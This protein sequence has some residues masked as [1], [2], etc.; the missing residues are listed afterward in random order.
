MSSIRND[1]HHQLDVLIHCT[2][3]PLSEYNKYPHL[4]TQDHPFTNFEGY[5]KD[6]GILTI[7]DSA[8]AMPVIISIENRFPFDINNITFEYVVQLYHGNKQDRI[9]VDFIKPDLI[10]SDQEWHDYL[11]DMSG[12]SRTLVD[13][14]NVSYNKKDSDIPLNQFTTNMP[15][16]IDS[17]EIQNAYNGFK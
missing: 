9:K 14:E 3:T 4:M 11:F 10:K 12:F 16:L 6:H 5:K 2:K 1:G 7:A 17:N 8:I 13:I 15:Y